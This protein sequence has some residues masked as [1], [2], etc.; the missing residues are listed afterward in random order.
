MKKIYL[1][2]VVICINAEIKADIA[3][4]P[5]QARGISAKFPTEV[6]MTYEKVTVSLTLDS[7]FVHCYFKL[8]NEGKAEKVQIG[9]PCMN[10]TPFTLKNSSVAP[11]NVY[12]NG[13]RIE[14]IN[15]L[16]SDSK[17]LKSKIN[18]WYL[19]NTFFEEN[20]T[21]VIEL[22]YSLPHGIV[23][24]DLYYKFDYL[25]STGS[26]W[27]G[28]I[29][30]AE[31]IVTLSNFEKNLILKTSPENYTASENQ[32]IWRLYNIEPTTKDDISIRYEKKVGQ[33][34]EKNKI[35]PSALI[36]LDEKTIVSNDIRHPNSIDSVYPKDILQVRIIKDTVE[37]KSRFPNIKSTNGLILFY[38]Y[39]FIPE[40]FIGI[41]NSKIVGLK[42]EPINPITLS[43]FSYKYSLEINGKKIKKEDI[44]I[45]VLKINES[46]IYQVSIKNLHKNKYRIIIRTIP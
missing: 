46:K 6:K 30:T 26:G 43:E 4:N 37:A 20:E 27:K 15:T 42:K 1:L 23:K 35:S 3:P 39:K 5:I 38:T 13:K 29:D 36:L 21:M 16:T 11:I 45:E 8:H 17:N 19:W 10:T 28:N 7:S 44:P 31:I 33:Y 40:R 12:K 2:I 18:T 32:L 9:Y 24:N 14:D 25:L 41:L 22:S 34:D